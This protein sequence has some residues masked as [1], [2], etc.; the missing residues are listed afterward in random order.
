MELLID[1]KHNGVDIFPDQIH[2]SNIENVD[3]IAANSQKFEYT[4]K[5]SWAHDTNIFVISKN[6]L[7]FFFN[8][9]SKLAWSQTKS[10]A[11]L[12]YFLGGDAID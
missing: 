11:I 5:F 4:I 6:K 10:I 2:I 8:A 7:L 1:F 12:F 3:N 9:L